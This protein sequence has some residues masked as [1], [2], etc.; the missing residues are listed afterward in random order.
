VLA[1]LSCGLEPDAGGCTGD[2][3]DRLGHVQHSLVTAGIGN[4]D[5]LTPTAAASQSI[6][7][8]TAVDVTVDVRTGGA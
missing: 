5:L 6:R 1:E 8:A 4:A 3:R 7:E 2:K